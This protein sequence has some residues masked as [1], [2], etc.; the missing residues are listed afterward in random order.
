[1]K[2]TRNQKLVY[3]YLEAHGKPAS[4][5][6]ILN[7]LRDELGPHVAAVM[8]ESVQ[9]EGGAKQV[10][11]GYL[12]GVRA[13]AD[14]YGALVIA[15]EVQAGIGRTGRL[16][17]FEDSKIKPDIVAIA[18]GLAGG[19]PIGAVL[20][21]KKVAS[22]MVPGTHGSTFGGNPLAMK[23]GSVIMDIIAKKSFLNDIFSV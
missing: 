8:V 21:N 13:A 18:K 15:D 5:Y 17:S 23:I 16:F 11:D 22:G 9:G 7:A 3:D 19:F 14:E 1:M 6:D 4:A 2:R 20:M 12:T 10:P